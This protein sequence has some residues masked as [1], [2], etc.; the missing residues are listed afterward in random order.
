MSASTQSADAPM[1]RSRTAGLERTGRSLTRSSSQ[2]P[3]TTNLK[4]SSQ[5]PPTTSGTPDD[6]NA[7]EHAFVKQP[8]RTAST[9]QH[10]ERSATPRATSPVSSRR[11]DDTT[12]IQQAR[13]NIK[14]LDRKLKRLEPPA[15]GDGSSAARTR[16]TEE[17]HERKTLAQQHD[18]TFAR[19]HSRTPQHVGDPKSRKRSPTNQARSSSPIRKAKVWCGNN[20]LDKALRINGGHLE[21]GSPH[22]CF[23]RGVGGGIHQEI[24]PGDEDAFLQK[25]NNQPYEKLVSQP[26]YYKSGPVPHGMFRCTLPQSL[27]RG[28]AIGCKQRAKSILK[29]RGHTAHDA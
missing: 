4:T 25:W 28:W 27:A 24:A 29:Q 9:A 23:Q 12:D 5:T 15:R 26:I 17:N 3:Q 14:R 21:I 10:D 20:K 13:G 19:D 22:A 6:A 8:E 1:S 11:S 7:R 18:S 16:W 2:R